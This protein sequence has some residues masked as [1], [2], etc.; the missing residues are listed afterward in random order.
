MKPTHLCRGVAVFCWLSLLTLLYTVTFGSAEG[1]GWAILFAVLTLIVHAIVR[2]IF[3]PYS[4]DNKTVQSSDAVW[5][6]DCDADKCGFYHV[7]RPCP[8]ECPN[9][10]KKG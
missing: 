2:D 3:W 10:N 9:F 4:E 8:S 6:N 7:G 1:Y 5:P